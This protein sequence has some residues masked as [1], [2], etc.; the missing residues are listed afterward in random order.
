MGLVGRGLGL[1][2]L[3]PTPL[4]RGERGFWVVAWAEGPPRCRWASQRLV[5]QRD[6]LGAGAAGVW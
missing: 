2:P 1:A 3:S 6:G 5:A 4:P